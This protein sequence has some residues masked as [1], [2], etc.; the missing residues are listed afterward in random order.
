MEN[1]YAI[2][3]LRK[4]DPDYKEMNRIQMMLCYAYN[5]HLALHQPER[6]DVEPILVRSLI[7]DLKQVQGNL[8]DDGNFREFEAAWARS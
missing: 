7:H 2:R 5:P 4:S 3:R 1:G 8:M 6:M